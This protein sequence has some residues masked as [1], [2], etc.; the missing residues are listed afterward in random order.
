MRVGVSQQCP[1]LLIPD[2]HMLGVFEA[3]RLP[4]GRAVVDLY[5]QVARAD[6]KGV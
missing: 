2:V 6:M 1:I 4:G 5:A 3:A